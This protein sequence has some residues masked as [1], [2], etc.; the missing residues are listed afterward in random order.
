M[1]FVFLIYSRSGFNFAQEED[2]LLF[3]LPDM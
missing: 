3:S 1:E 2:T